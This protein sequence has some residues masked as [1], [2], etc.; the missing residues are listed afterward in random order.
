M[1]SI[2]LF[3]HKLGYPKIEKTIKDKTKITGEALLTNLNAP[4][5]YH[6]N[7]LDQA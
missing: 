5:I 7:S 2:D 1:V 3:L 6:I 4:T